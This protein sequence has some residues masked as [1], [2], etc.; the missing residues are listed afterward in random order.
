MLVWG[1]LALG[2]G[3]G[4][5][6][7]D[8]GKDLSIQL[9]VDQAVGV[10]VADTFTFSFVSRGRAL[11]GIELDFGDGGTETINGAGSSK[12]TGTRVH[13][14]QQPGTYSAVAR[15]VEMVGTELADTVSVQVQ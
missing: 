1:V 3:C 9:T 11:L 12:V 6:S 2:S 14:Y 8:S 10:A 13:A 15:A 7:T 4:G 5:S